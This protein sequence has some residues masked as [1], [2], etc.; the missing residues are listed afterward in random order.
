MPSGG[1]VGLEINGHVLAR[2]PVRRINCDCVQE[3]KRH[4]DLAALV[5]QRMNSVAADRLQEL[6]REIDRRVYDLYGLLDEE[7]AQV[8]STTPLA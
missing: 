4:D 8:E 7:I 6:D 2:S 5:G 1:G 3:R